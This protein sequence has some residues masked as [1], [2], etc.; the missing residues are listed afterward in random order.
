MLHEF[1][2]DFPFSNQSGNLTLEKCLHGHVRLLGHGL[3]RLVHRLQN[4][5]SGG[6]SSSN[7]W[8]VKNRR[9]FEVK[10]RL[11]NLG[12]TGDREQQGGHAG[13][14][15]HR[16]RRPAR[17]T[18]RYHLSAQHCS[19]PVTQRER[20]RRRPPEAELLLQVE[21]GPN[22]GTWQTMCPFYAGLNSRITLFSVSVVTFSSFTV[23]F[24]SLQSHAAPCCALHVNTS[25]IIQ[26]K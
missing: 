7:L 10:M 23:C 6:T 13:L 20:D 26:P 3:Q 1:C 5:T 21:H 24:A 2:S 11:L 4:R 18:H 12:E 16:N 19:P 9:E 22:P 15:A 8:V 14:V 17:W 25:T